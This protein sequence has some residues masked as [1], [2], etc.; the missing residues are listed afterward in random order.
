[1][2]GGRF[3]YDFTAGALARVHRFPPKKAWPNEMLYSYGN[4]ERNM[5]GEI[6][7]HP[8]SD[9]ETAITFRSFSGAN[10]L[11]HRFRLRPKDLGLSAP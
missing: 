9:T 5:F 10:G 6:D 4:T 3:L 8:A 1:M 7:F 2:G 11:S